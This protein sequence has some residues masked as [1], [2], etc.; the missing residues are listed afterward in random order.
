MVRLSG[1]KVSSK[2]D[3][4]ALEDYQSDPQILETLMRFEPLPDVLWEPA[5]GLGNLVTVLRN[6]GRTVY[7]T[8]INDAY[9]AMHGHMALD[10]LEAEMP[11]TVRPKAILTNP[12]FSLMARFAK[13][14][15]DLGLEAY[16]FARLNFMEGGERDPIRDAILEYRKGLNRVFVLRERPK[17]MHRTGYE[18]PKSPT[19]MTLAWFHFKPKFRGEAKIRRISRHKLGPPLP[20]PRPKDGTRNRCGDTMEM[21][22]GEAVA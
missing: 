20:P 15:M 17:E 22:E 18:G 3:R 12:P 11:T 19:Q 9:A 8:D 6:A 13:H 2:A 1:N 16:L 14:A 10:F 4:G 7:A 5:A 21:F